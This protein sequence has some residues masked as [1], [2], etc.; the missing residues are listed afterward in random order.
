VI[1]RLLAPYL[2][3]LTSM[4]VPL[5]NAKAKAELGWRPKYPTIRDWLAPIARRA[6]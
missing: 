5:S 4:R 3:R 1:P 6:A 2:A